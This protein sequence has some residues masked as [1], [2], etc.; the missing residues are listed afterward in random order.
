MKGQDVYVVG[1]AN[2]AGQ[3]ATHLSKYASRVTLLVRGHSLSTS[4]SDYLTKE[5]GAA[6]NI[7]VRF[8][9]RV[10]DGGGEGR[11]ERLVLE[12]TA[13]GVTDTVA[14]TALFV[15]I[16]AEPRTEWLPKEIERDREGFIVTGSDL[17]LGGRP[18]EGWSLVRSPLLMETSMPG[19]FA[20]G[21][22][23]AGSVKR[24]AS[25]V[26]EGAIAIQSVHEH[27]MIARSR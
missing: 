14:A 24:I 18:P 19:V 15:L 1:G 7:E 21:D 3:A 22:I 12:N 2:S 8:N 6:E 9:S 25:A 23:R 27:L 13:S 20:V 16:G 17:L 5:I 11:L 26:G 10:I 4:M